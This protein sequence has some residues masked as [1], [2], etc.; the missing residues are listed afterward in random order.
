MLLIFSLLGR[1]PFLQLMFI[2]DGLLCALNSAK[3]IYFS[4]FI[5]R[6]LQPI[7]RTM[8][9]R[10]TIEIFAFEILNLR[11]EKYVY[12]LIASL[13]ARLDAQ[14]AICLVTARVHAW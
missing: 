3:I 7:P 1:L 2:S 11:V 4:F 14:F 6:G 8:A 12:T 13:Y 10:P 9:C 5:T